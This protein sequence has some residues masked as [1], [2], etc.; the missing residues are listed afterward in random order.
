MDQNKLGKYILAF[1][2][3]NEVIALGLGRIC[4][5]KAIEIAYSS[6]SP[7]H[8][9]SNTQLIPQIDAMLDSLGI[10]RDEIACVCVGRGPGSFTGVRIAMATAKGI[11]S[12]L[13]LPLIGISTQN[14]VAQ[15]VKAAGFT[16]KLLVASDAMRKEIYPAYFNISDEVERF[17][18][19]KVVKV[20]EF[21]DD[22][23]H[24]NASPHVEDASKFEDSSNVCEPDRIEDANHVGE[25]SRIEEVSHVGDSLMIC[26][27]ALLKYYD[28]LSGLGTVLPEELWVPTGKGL[29][30]ELQ[31]LW[32]SRNM[33]IFDVQAND[34]LG[35]LPIYTR[36]SDAEEAERRKLSSPG[37]R[38]LITGVQGNKATGVIT[39]SMAPDGSY[40]KGEVSYRPLDVKYAEDVSAMEDRYLGSDAW[41]TSMVSDDLSRA[42]RSWWM[43]AIDGELIGYAGIR[44]TDGASELLKI[45]VSEDFRRKGVAKELISKVAYDAFNLASKELTLEVRASN[46]GAQDFYKSMGFEC[47]GARPKY[48]SDGEDAMIFTASLPM[49]FDSQTDISVDAAQEEILSRPLILAIES[50]CDETAAAVVDGEGRV[51]SNVVSSQ[52]DFHARFGGVVPEIASRKHVEAIVGVARLALESAS[53]P[54]IDSLDFSDLDAI[55]VTYA[56]GLVGALVVGVAFAKGAAWAVDIPLIAVN[57]LEGHMY[58][59]K[60]AAPIVSGETCESSDKVRNTQSDK[61]DFPAVV[62]L[63]SGGNTMLVLMRDWQDYEILGATID[64]AVGEAFDKVAKAMGFPY[65]GGPQI[66]RLAEKGDPEAIDFPRA[67]MHSGDYRFSLS[68]MKT[69]VISYIAKERDSGNTLNLPDI[70]ASFE[71]AIIDVQVAKARTALLETGAKSFCLGG[72]VAANKQL[73]LAYE[74]MCGEIGVHVIMP[75]L[76]ACGDNAAMIALVALDRYR[77][78]KFAQLD[79]DAFAHANLEDPY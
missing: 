53:V 58:A 44:V 29:L 70:C 21:V 37:E 74:K 16:G 42:D 28:L 61:L 75:P 4:G 26:G 10:H 11:A 79:Q 32:R 5:D 25:S 50:S 14:A 55:G 12:A 41:T 34:P 7:A 71:Q 76:S 63:V 43:A 73:R 57:H 49:R 13:G 6:E 9:Q 1:D 51:L 40:E 65:P 3:S 64:D 27:D 22:L 78:R 24:V 18:A 52:I 31:D 33:D 2:T 66:S 68:G 36:L 45:V 77:Q 60:L 8:R 23:I 30:L 38:N 59:N 48:Y 56:P 46:V 54:S 17:S 19:D 72:G 39:E 62:S 67:L 15:G 20:K 47:A 35:V 69:A